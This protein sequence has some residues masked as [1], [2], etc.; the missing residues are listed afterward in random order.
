MCLFNDAFNIKDQVE[1][2]S[3]HQN[4]I[5]NKFTEHSRVLCCCQKIRSEDSIISEIVCIPAYQISVSFIRCLLGASW[6][7]ELSGA[8]FRTIPGLWSFGTL[9]VGGAGGID[10]ALQAFF[11]VINLSVNKFW[12]NKQITEH[13]LVLERENPT[14]LAEKN[15]KLPVNQKKKKKCSILYSRFIS[16]VLTWTQH[17]VLCSYA[18]KYVSDKTDEFLHYLVY[19]FIS[20]FFVKTWRCF[21]LIIFRFFPHAKMHILPFEV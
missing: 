10:P 20:D 5:D 8:M 13:A 3:L 12:Q 4:E 6:G 18:Q 7:V 19:F 1:F 21:F 17:I 2:W 11:A 9:R 14:D 16:Q 15:M